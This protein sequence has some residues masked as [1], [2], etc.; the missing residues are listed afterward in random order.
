VLGMEAKYLDSIFHKTSIIRRLLVR[1]KIHRI[2]F[3]NKKDIFNQLNA[4][5]ILDKP[6][7]R[8]QLQG[9]R[10]KVASLGV[11]FLDLTIKTY[12]V[13]KI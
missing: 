12:R 1:F 5:L 11:H 9:M 3:N 4:S 8:M 7:Q 6:F 2:Y 10:V 13:F